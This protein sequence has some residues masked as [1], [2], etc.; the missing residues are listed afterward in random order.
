M[1]FLH[2]ELCRL[3]SVAGHL[4]VYNGDNESIW[5]V[6]WLNAQAIQLLKDQG[7]DTLHYR[8][9]SGISF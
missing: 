5:V 7:P 6:R 8:V 4:Q 9:Y 3:T 2:K 1:D